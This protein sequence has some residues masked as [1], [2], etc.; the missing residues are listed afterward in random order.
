MAIKDVS[1]LFI[2]KKDTG[3]GVGGGTKGRKKPKPGLVFF[4]F[5]FGQEITQKGRQER[6]LQ[7]LVQIELCRKMSS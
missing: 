2:S 7:S 1:L 4:F 6:K 5:F 3:V